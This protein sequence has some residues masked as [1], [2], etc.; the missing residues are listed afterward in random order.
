MTL[1]AIGAAESLI[2]GSLF[3]AL[4]KVSFTLAC[5]R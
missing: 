3:F 1:I 4:I 2:V 5:P